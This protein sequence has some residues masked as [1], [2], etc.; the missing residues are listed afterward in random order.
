[1]IDELIARMDAIEA[2]L[3]VSGDR[4][5][6]FH[7]TYNRMTHAIRDEIRGGGFADSAWVERW[8][9]AFAGYYL[10]ALTRWRSG[11]SP[12]GPW[13]VTLD[14]SRTRLAPLRHVL[15]GMNA[16]INFDLPQALLDVISD[17]ELADERLLASRAEDHR[18]VDSLLAARVAEEDRELRAFEEPGDRT[19]VDAALTPFNRSGTKRFLAEARAKVWANTLVLAAARRLG[20]DAYARRLAELEELAAAKVADLLRPGH[21][22]LRLARRGF[23]V[24]L[25]P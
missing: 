14:A 3:T 18:H 13:A 9:V 11:G 1:V 20:P 24:V 6:I 7:G 21:V 8:D 2:D 16:H 17:D 4:N 19:W 25:T 22:L 15:L 23:G 5:R 10:E 12:S